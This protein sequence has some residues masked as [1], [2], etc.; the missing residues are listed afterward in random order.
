MTQGVAQCRQL[1]TS[2]AAFLIFQIDPLGEKNK[3]IIIVEV[4]M[5]NREND[6]D[7][8]R[9]IAKAQPEAIRDTSF[10]TKP[11]VSN[12]YSLFLLHPL[13]ARIIPPTPIPYL[14]YFPVNGIRE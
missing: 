13:V 2:C 6:G 11:S 3:Q 14:S 1:K 4:N 7:V 8:R 12:C 5:G 10:E 9:V